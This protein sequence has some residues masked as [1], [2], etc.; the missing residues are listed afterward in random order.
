MT[1]LTTIK[2][3][4]T[5]RI[6]K[7]ALLIFFVSSLLY[8]YTFLIQVMP[9]A[10]ARP[11][12]HDFVVSTTTFGIF[13]SSFYWLYT[14]AQIPAGLLIDRFGSRI[15][16]S[17]ATLICGLGTIVFGLTHSIDVAIL[18][19]TLEGVTAAFSFTAV[20]YL[21]I[22]WFPPATLAMFAGVLQLLA[23]IGAISGGS[24]FADMLNYY[25]WRTIVIAIGCIGIIVALVM[26]Y[27][28]KNHPAET[29]PIKI[30]TKEK[31][32][33]KL[34]MLDSMEIVLNNP[35][36]WYVAIYAFCIWGPTLAFA[37]LWGIPFLKTSLHLSTLHAANAIAIVW[38]GIGLGSPIIGLVSDKI[39]KRRLPLII[40]ALIGMVSM[41]CIIY[42]PNTMPRFI[43]YIMLFLVGTAL[44]AQALTFA[45]VKDNNHI[46][47][48]GAA[49]GFNNMAVVLGGVILQPFIGKLLDMN[50]QGIIVNGSRTYQL[51]NYYTAF[52]ILPLCFLIAIIMSILFI[53]ETHCKPVYT[54][55]DL[56]HKKLP[57][58]ATLQPL[59]NDLLGTYNIQHSIRHFYF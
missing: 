25:P 36:T 8:C 17:T 54:S 59:S 50:F 24:L 40:A 30:T 57:K 11:L 55:I 7:A 14:S 52:A 31:P 28:I 22:R 18:S 47:T 39:K 32:L 29:K 35:Q 51:H 43:L 41:A 26:W 42:I 4:H 58:T 56:A 44:S 53:K 23:S 15:T 2:E 13:S 37:A 1:D 33:P 6:T 5:K 49:I 48:A 21:V 20:I 34:S 12:M 16:L 45:V 38:I 3:D 19:R 10:I 46:R 9:S 27:I